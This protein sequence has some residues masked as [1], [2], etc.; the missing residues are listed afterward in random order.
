MYS[1]NSFTASPFIKPID[2][3]PMPVRVGGAAYA[4]KGESHSLQRGAGTLTNVSWFV[5]RGVGTTEILADVSAASHTYT[6]NSKMTSIQ[7]TASQAGK[8]LNVIGGAIGVSLVNS[9]EMVVNGD[10][11]LPVSQKESVFGGIITNRV[12]GF[13]LAPGTPAAL[14]GF[15]FHLPDYRPES[16]T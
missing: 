4:I 16:G 9:V 13:R 6:G 12:W 11:Y 5:N 3:T 8:T 15:V 10:F 7:I 1:S 2:E 14:A